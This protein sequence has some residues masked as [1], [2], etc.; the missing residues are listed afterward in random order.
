MSRNWQ[1]HSRGERE[2]NRWSGLGL[3]CSETAEVAGSL[4]G[5]SKVGGRLGPEKG[6][7]QP[8]GKQY[9]RQGK[10]CVAARHPGGLTCSSG[11]FFKVLPGH[12]MNLQVSIMMQTPDQPRACREE[13]LGF[14]APKFF[15]LEA[16]PC[17]SALGK[18]HSR[19][20]INLR[21]VVE[22][23]E[24]LDHPCMRVILLTYCL[25]APFLPS[26][27]QNQ[28]VLIWATVSEWLLTPTLMLSTGGWVDCF[29]AAQTYKLIISKGG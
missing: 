27:P 17:S 10:Q 21:G 23:G 3:Q 8:G 11:N 1:D 25:P 18:T 16:E 22:K 14:S 4:G 24:W 12:Q 20:Q 7:E 13:K 15:S 2:G 29:R 9:A 26:L 5:W 6:Q 28:T 19:H